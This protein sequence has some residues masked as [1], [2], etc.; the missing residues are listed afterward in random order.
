MWSVLRDRSEADRRLVF[1]ALRRREGYT[2]TTEKQQQAERALRAFDA[3]E[4]SWPSRRRYDR[5]RDRQPNPS[6]WPSSSLIRGAYGSW[7]DAIA[8][9]SAGATPDVLSRRLNARGEKFERDELLDALRVWRAQAP[10]PLRQT[11]L[12]AWCRQERDRGSR[13]VPRCFE[14]FRREFGSWDGTLDV[15]RGRE[16]TESAL[17]TSADFAAAP[18]TVSDAAEAT[19]ELL[20]WMAWIG[21][22]D[23]RPATLSAERYDALAAAFNRQ[24]Q[25]AGC[26]KRAPRARRLLLRF[27]SW[28]EARE[29]AGLC[30][31][32]QSSAR[33]QGQYFTR[34]QLLDACAKALLAVGLGMQTREYDAWSDGEVQ[35]ADR[36]GRP[37]PSGSSRGHAA[38]TA[39]RAGQAVVGGDRGDAALSSRAGAEARR[40]SAA[41]R[42]NASEVAQ[43][44]ATLAAD[45]Q[46]LGDGPAAELARLLGHSLAATSAAHRRDAR[47]GLLFEIVGRGS[48]EVPTEAA[49]EE[50]RVARAAAGEDWPTAQAL[51]Q[52][53]GHWLSA[54]RA[55]MRPVSRGEP[56]ASARGETEPRKRPVQ[57]ISGAASGGRGEH[58]HSARG[59]VRSPP[60]GRVTPSRGAIGANSVRGR[61]S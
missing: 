1:E 39:R 6:A 43:T 5:W 41:G 11:D 26:D 52:A 29:Q 19:G 51:G 10:Q 37:G 48:G 60:C 55:A 23:S 30:T 8:A 3:E 21:R 47:L 57:A 38:A 22:W 20:A 17:F 36:P 58:P 7:P 24:A 12:L 15:A 59:N 32:A 4:G 35:R 61:K 49:Y 18:P 46:A 44:L 27:R 45:R 16:A 14:P 13:W 40:V 28:P 54:V 50:V 53:Y 42:G 34:H 31:A 56:R 9:V 2:Q 33:R 25:T